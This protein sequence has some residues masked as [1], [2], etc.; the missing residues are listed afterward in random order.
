LINPDILPI[1]STAISLNSLQNSN[2]ISGGM[3]ETKQDIIEISDCDYLLFQEFLRFLY[4]GQVKKDQ[5]LVIKLFHFADKYLQ[6][7][8]REKCVEFLKYDINQDN[9]YKIL[10][11]AHQE[12]IS[13]LRHWCVD[14]LKDKINLNNISSLVEHLNKQNDPELAQENLELRDK[15]IYFLTNNYIEATKNQNM[16][17]FEDFLIKNIAL[18]TVSTL[19]NFVSGCPVKIQVS[20]ELFSKSNHKGERVEGLKEKLQPVTINL[21]DALYGFVQTNLETLTQTKIIEKIPHEFLVDL[22]RRITKTQGQDQ[23]KLHGEQQTS[24]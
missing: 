10:D 7:D 24:Q 6:N 22:L 1:F 13:H 21:R 9:V 3:S 14:F 11:F 2:F 16:P 19:A 17:V 12:D 23:R 8:L 5:D 4:T 18:E 20:C 15:V